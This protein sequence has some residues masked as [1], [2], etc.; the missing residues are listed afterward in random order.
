MF[1]LGSGP[2]PETAKAHRDGVRST[3]EPMRNESV[4]FQILVELKVTFFNTL[5]ETLGRGIGW[6]DSPTSKIR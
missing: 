1:R 3:R 5:D 6:S 2:R 4:S